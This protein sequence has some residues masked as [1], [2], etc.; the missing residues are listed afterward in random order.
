MIMNTWKKF[1][2]G[3]QR[4]KAA[5]CPGGLLQKEIHF[6]LMAKWQQSSGGFRLFFINWICPTIG[7]SVLSLLYFLIYLGKTSLM[8][9]YFTLSCQW[10]HIIFCILAVKRVGTILKDSMKGF[11]RLLLQCKLLTISWSMEKYFYFIL[12]P[13]FWWGKKSRSRLMN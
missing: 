5:N 4:T 1:K 8:C 7:F 9:T 13:L 3:S 10:P 6:G 11:Y 2:G 12:N